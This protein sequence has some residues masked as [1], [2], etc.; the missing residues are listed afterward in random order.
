MNIVIDVLNFRLFV[1]FSSIESYNNYTHDQ[2]INILVKL[3]SLT[4]LSNRYMD[5]VLL[6]Q[7]ICR[8]RYEGFRVTLS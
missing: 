4:T 7:N 3:F 6:E 8:M 1:E 5:W 2:Y